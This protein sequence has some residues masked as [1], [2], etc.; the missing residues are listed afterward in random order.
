MREEEGREGRAFLPGIKK[1][2]VSNLTS[3]QRKTGRARERKKDGTKVHVK[4]GVF[5]GSVAYRIQCVAVL[6]LVGIGT[7]S[8][9]CAVLVSIYLHLARQWSVQISKHYRP[10]SHDKVENFSKGHSHVSGL[11]E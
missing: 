4:S 10:F 7:G 3:F 11:R 8:M 1:H 9:Y 6:V 5:P 2:Q